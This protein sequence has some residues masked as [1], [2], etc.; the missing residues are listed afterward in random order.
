MKTAIEVSNLNEV[1]IKLTEHAELAKRE[2]LEASSLIKAVTNDLT[3]QMAADANVAIKKVLKAVESSRKDVKAPVLEMGR[4]I[5]ALAKEFIE[6]LEIE[7]SRIDHLIVPYELEKRKAAQIL[8]EQR[9]ASIKSLKEGTP[10]WEEAV[11]GKPVEAA[12]TEGMVGVMV[13]KFEVLNIMELVKTHPHL[14]RCEPNVAQIN[15]FLKAGHPVPSSIR[16]WKEMDIRA[17]AS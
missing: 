7:E 10:E 17:R 4:K 13:D 11:R 1:S 16:A 12:K 14:V 5:D 3:Q 15:A 6:E 8:E 2:A 9:Q